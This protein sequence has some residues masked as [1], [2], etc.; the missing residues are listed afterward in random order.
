MANR[1]PLK[2]SGATEKQLSAIDVKMEQA[3]TATTHM[4][5]CT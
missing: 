4:A 2:K 3:R 5:E 1:D